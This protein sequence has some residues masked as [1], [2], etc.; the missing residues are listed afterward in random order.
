MDSRTSMTAN[1]PSTPPSY[2]YGEPWGY[3]MSVV[4]ALV[5]FIISVFA[6]FGF[7]NYVLKIDLM[8][9][10]MDNPYDGVALSSATI[11]SST[12][13]VAILLLV[14]RI[15]KWPIARYLGLRMPSREEAIRAIGAMVVLIAVVETIVTVLGQST[16]PT[17]Q[18]VAYRTAKAAGWLPMLFAAI[19]IFGPI[20]EEVM[21][22]GFL[23]RGFVRRVGHEPFAIFVITIAWT[24]CHLQY[25][26]Q[27]MLQVFVMGLLFGA[28]R[29]WTGS[30]ALTIMMHVLANLWAMI[31]TLI[32]I[33]WLKA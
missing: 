12:V 4:W 17:F 22:R 33:E 26:L 9:V 19:V 21:F 24:A 18:L 8:K 20:A 14:V 25:D 27:E 5:A 6:A 7:M 28:V 16:V 32:W 3:V 1:T 15:K 2:A 10:M 31:E 29:W 23:Y 13:Q 11:V 30:T